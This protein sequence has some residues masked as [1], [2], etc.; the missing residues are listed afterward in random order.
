MEQIAEHQERAHIAEVKL[1]EIKTR[2]QALINFVSRGLLGEDD[3][4]GELGNLKEE[5][6]KL[7]LELAQLNQSIANSDPTYLVNRISRDL[8]R[9]PLFAKSLMISGARRLW[10]LLIT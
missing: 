2:Q 5:R 3:I 8:E 1:E 4:A 10:Q 7:R 9:L 6:D